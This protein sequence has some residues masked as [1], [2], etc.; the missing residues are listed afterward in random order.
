MVPVVPV[1]LWGPPPG[2]DGWRIGGE[3]VLRSPRPNLPFFQRKS[4]SAASRIRTNPEIPPTIPPIR[5]GVAGVLLPPPEAE[6][7]L[8]VEVGAPAVLLAPPIPPTPAPVLAALVPAADGD[9]PVPKAEV[10]VI[11]VV[12][13][14]WLPVTEPE[15]L[16]N[17]EE[18]AASMDDR[19]AWDADI[20]AR[21]AASMELDDE[22]NAFKAL[23]VI[24]PVKDVD[25]TV[26]L[27]LVDLV[28]VGALV[29]SKAE[30]ADGAVVPP[31]AGDDVK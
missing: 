29:D 7:A 16:R 18:L 4:R 31:Y 25:G 14:A 9:W 26:E 1:P 6:P 27:L 11:I 10:I 22:L 12:C 2:A 19:D 15:V 20:A 28:S 30:V 13:E 3:I 23:E 17:L 21:R 24:E 5:A 8:D